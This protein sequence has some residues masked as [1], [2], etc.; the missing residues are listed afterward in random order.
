[1]RPK[2]LLLCLLLVILP[3]FALA[4]EENANIIRFEIG[5]KQATYPADAYS[6]VDVE[7]AEIKNSEGALLPDGTLF[8][9]SLLAVDN[10][11][12]SSDV[13]F[14]SYFEARED[15]SEEDGFQVASS[16][17]KLAFSFKT[18]VIAGNY[19]LA[20]SRLEEGKQYYGEFYLVLSEF[21]PLLIQDVDIVPERPALKDKAKVAIKSYTP[22]PSY[23]IEFAPIQLLEKDGKKVFQ[24]N[25][26]SK[27]IVGPNE[28]VAQQVQR[29]D[30]TLDLPK[31]S[32]VSEYTLRI[33]ENGSVIKEHVFNIEDD[34]TIWL[35]RD[36]SNRHWAYNYIKQLVQEEVV[37]GYADGNFRPENSITRAEFL[38]VVLNGAKVE[39]LTGLSSAFSDVTDDAW[40]KNY[41]MTAKGLGI[42]GGYED[43]TFRPDQPILR[44]EATKV[45]LEAFQIPTIRVIDP[46]FDDVSEEWLT[47]VETGVV[48]DFWHGRSERIFEPRDYITRAEVS[49]I[50]DRIWD[51]EE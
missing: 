39:L 5:A 45:I 31:A 44:Q 51:L 24:L 37:G 27:R 35:F 29:Y 42:I 34:T 43:A 33:Y 13:T 26:W 23:E 16:G 25:I 46:T 38:K 14:A 30:M 22:T 20:A 28:V 49:K 15:Q 7:S 40:Y 1:M 6:F 36:V 50:V 11:Y 2:V 19:K 21:K 12:K 47:Y 10:V 41:V 3:Q 18:G 17:G 8:T 48:Y 32:E 9:V 4:E